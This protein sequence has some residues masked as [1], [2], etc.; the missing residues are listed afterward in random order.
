[1]ASVPGSIGGSLAGVI[2]T[3]AKI[4]PADGFHLTLSCVQ[5]IVIASGKGASIQ[6]REIWQGTQTVT[7][8]LLD[9]RAAVSA[10]DRKSVV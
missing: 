5:R 7:H 10:I 9:D 2:Q 3:S 8:E 4:R 6:E 1:M